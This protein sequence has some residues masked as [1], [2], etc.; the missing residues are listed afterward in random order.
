MG[1]LSWRTIGAIV[2][3]ALL[4]VAAQLAPAAKRRHCQGHLAKTQELGPRAARLPV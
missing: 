2:G 1:A 4:G 3:A